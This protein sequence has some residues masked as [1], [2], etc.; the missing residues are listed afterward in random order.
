MP[1]TPEL[2]EL[3]HSA[4]VVPVAAA[5]EVVDP[6]RELTC[7]DKPSNGVPAHITLLYPFLPAGAID[8]RLEREL[9]HLFAD[10]ASW[11]APAFVDT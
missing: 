3:L 5:A 2:N 11:N 10:A 1:I 8:K 4:L 6:W 9:T 7:E